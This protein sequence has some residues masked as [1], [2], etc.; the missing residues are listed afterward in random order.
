MSKKRWGTAII[1]G[2]IKEQENKTF[3]EKLIESVEQ[4]IVIK[5]EREKSEKKKDN[6]WKNDPVEYAKRMASGDKHCE[7]DPIITS[8]MGYSYFLDEDYTYVTCGI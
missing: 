3:G 4:A 8:Y 2:L 7:M 1:E 5:K 6:E